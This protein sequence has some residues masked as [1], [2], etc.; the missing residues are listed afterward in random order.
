MRFTGK[1]KESFEKWY[2]TNEKYDILLDSSW[3]TFLNDS[4]EFEGLPFSM[5]SGVMLEYLDSV[6]IDLYIDVE[7]DMIIKSIG[8]VYYINGQL[9][10][11][12]SFDTRQEALKEAIKKADEILNNQ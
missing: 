1:N 2:K 4:E 5:Q 8:F 9:V 10:N 12:Q 7:K 6:E 3:G 11:G